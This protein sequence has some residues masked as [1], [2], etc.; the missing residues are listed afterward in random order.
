MDGSYDDVQD[1]IDQMTG[2]TDQYTDANTKIYDGFKAVAFDQVKI[3]GNGTTI[4]KIYYERN[5]YNVDANYNE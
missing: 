3:K 5:Y 4:V 2:T 1:D